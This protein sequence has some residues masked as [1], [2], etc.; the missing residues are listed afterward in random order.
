MSRI[1]AILENMLGE[2]NQLEPPQSRIEAL[3]MALYDQMIEN[4]MIPVTAEE[5]T[6]IVDS[7]S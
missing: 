4:E 3:C 6:E 7:L 5:I 1:E 2:H